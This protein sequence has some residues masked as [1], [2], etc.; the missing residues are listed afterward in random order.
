MILHLLLFLEKSIRGGRRG[1]KYEEKNQN[2]S[3]PHHL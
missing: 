2:F 1:E 3:L